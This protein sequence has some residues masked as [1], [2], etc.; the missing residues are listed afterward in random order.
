MER[1]RQ[2][3]TYTANSPHSLTGRLDVFQSWLGQFEEEKSPWSM[4][5]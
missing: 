4:K 5:F 1:R 3:D 2:L